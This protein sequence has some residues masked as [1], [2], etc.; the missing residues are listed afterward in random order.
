MSMRDHPE[1]AKVF[2]MLTAPTCAACL[3]H[4]A[5]ARHMDALVEVFEQTAKRGR[6]L[7]NGFCC[8]C[9]EYKTVIYPA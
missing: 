7:A 2:S 9:R 8:V 6:C 4:E 3:L 5:D 1:Y